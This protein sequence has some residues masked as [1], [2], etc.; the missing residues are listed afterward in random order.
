MKVE[1]R[2]H[3]LPAI[4]PSDPAPPRP[5]GHW[6]ARLSP[7]WRLSLTVTALTRVLFF[8]TAYAAQRLLAEVTGLPE[9]GVFKIWARFD[10]VHLISVARHGYS[11]PHTDPH[12]SVFF[13][14]YPL[15]IRALMFVNLS[16][17]A[18]GLLI[19]T[20]ASCFAFHF[21][22]KLAEER[23]GEEAAA[24]AVLYLAFF[25]AALFLVAPYVESL[26]LAGASAA[27]FYARRGRWG[28]A[29]L[30]IAVATASRAVGI[31]L[32]LGLIAELLRQGSLSRTR[33]FAAGRWLLIG[34]LPLVAFIG[35]LWQLH[36]TPLAFLH[37]QTSGW[38]REFVGPLVSLQNTLSMLEIKQ[39]PPGWVMT[40]WGELAAALI[41]LALFTWTIAKKEWGYAVYVG[42][43]LAALLTSTWYYSLPRLLLALFPLPIMIAEFSAGHRAR[44]DWILITSAGL[45][46]L[47][48]IIFTS[49]LWFY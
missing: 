29:T 30:G 13:P 12:A 40:I 22:F 48:V 15:L 4:P 1:P 21:V 49:G 42:T 43:T 41:G 37:D 38:Q 7:S 17:L 5:F 44:H 24:K 18:A 10:A 33:I 47:G 23:L 11:G 31:F 39:Y 36:G 45:A 34:S 46:T 35:Y 16:P 2:V 3:S 19:S 8:T 9:R 27:F 32:V 26:F 14:L 6:I 25:P 20:V 28:A